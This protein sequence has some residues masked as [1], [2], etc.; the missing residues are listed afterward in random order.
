MKRRLATNRSC[1]DRTRRPW[2]NPFLCVTQNWECFAPT[3]HVSCTCMSFASKVH[4][5]V[6]N[7]CHLEHD[8]QCSMIIWIC[9]MLITGKS[10]VVFDHL[11]SWMF[12]GFFNSPALF[13]V[14]THRDLVP[15]R[16]AFRT[17]CPTWVLKERHK[18]WSPV[19]TLDGYNETGLQRPFQA[20]QNLGILTGS[21]L[22]NSNMSNYV[23]LVPMSSTPTATYSRRLLFV[24]DQPPPQHQVLGR[25]NPD[26]TH[27]QQRPGTL[28][29]PSVSNDLQQS[30]ITVQ[31]S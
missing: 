7:F 30:E 19:I 6:F 23:H 4:E 1:E 20:F 8:V 28:L 22:G 2:T 3:T 18:Y 14:P 11:W 31:S 16:F 12:H 15:F 10:H 26:R 5:C 29:G 25:V 17:R 27:L 21:L 9:L 13:S 24:V